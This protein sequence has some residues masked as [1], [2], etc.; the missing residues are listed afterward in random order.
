MT[1]GLGVLGVA[2]IAPLSIFRELPFVPELSLRALA[3]RRS[4]AADQQAH[5]YGLACA[6][7]DYDALLRMP[8]V[9]CVYIPAA[10]A[11]HR[12]WAEIA[13]HHDKHVLI[14]KPLA[15]SAADAMALQACA[16]AC[17]RRVVEA[18]MVRHHP[19]QA[20]LRQRVRERTWG[21][22]LRTRTLLRHGL[23]E[24]DHFRL[25]PGGGVLWDDGVYWLQALQ[26]VA[27]ADLPSASVASIATDRQDPP[28]DAQVELV[29]GDGVLARFD[30]QFALPRRAMH[31]FEFEYATA[32]LQ[33]FFRA[34]IGAHKLYLD[35]AHASGQ[36]ERVEF[37]AQN[38]YRNQLRYIAS[39]ADADDW[40]MQMGLSIARIALLER[41]NAGA[42]DEASR[43]RN[44]SSAPREQA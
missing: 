3:S 28:R 17:G 40:A 11:E 22:L 14:E 2:E 42:M 15:L 27:D 12:L 44:A 37:E 9:D 43:Q 30:A 21:R 36:T 18:V 31:T 20:W 39:G 34:R 25:R 29:L 38:D 16:Q 32:T 6:C 26:A 7:T 10:N 8:E 19:W 5:R 33:D 24:N 23:R 41:L 13:L 4:G 1:I 35:I